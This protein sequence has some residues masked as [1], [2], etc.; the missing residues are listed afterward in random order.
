MDTSEHPEPYLIW[1]ETAYA[2]DPRVNGSLLPKSE[3]IRWIKRGV[4]L[5]LVM[6][7]LPPVPYRVGPIWL[8]SLAAG[9]AAAVLIALL[10]VLPLRRVVPSF[11]N[12]I[13]VPAHRKLSEWAI[14]LT[15]LH[16][17]LFVASDTQTIE[18]LKPAQPVFM[19]A[20]N[21]G[22]ILMAIV[23]ATSLETPRVVFIKSM[24]GFR[25]IHIVLSIAVVVLIGLHV[26]GS[27]TFINGPLKPLI[28]TAI[29]A[30]IILKTLRAGLRPERSNSN[31]PESENDSPREVQP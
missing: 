10:M 23:W 9:Y 29:S 2:A 25:S 16:L 1:N 5:A 18:Y 13:S 30:Y 15:I 24:L 28:F 11:Q 21:V 7:A 12:R 3:L 6:I 31:L 17:V 14:G 20:G 22:L 26:L 19:V 8:L 27:A 4:F